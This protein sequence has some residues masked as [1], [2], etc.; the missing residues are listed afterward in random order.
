MPTEKEAEERAK[1]RRR[2][3]AIEAFLARAV[4]QKPNE[5][6][7]AVPKATTPGEQ[8]I[9]GARLL[10]EDA[11]A[12]EQLK[13][14]VPEA[15]KAFE[16]YA[17]AQDAVNALKQVGPKPLVSEALQKPAEKRSDER[18]EKCNGA[19]KIGREQTLSGGR[20]KALDDL[21]KLYRMAA[22]DPSG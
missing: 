9:R 10:I 5:V 19:V 11:L 7:E 21:R 13:A 20:L 4:E 17:D 6:S 18:W 12:D 3:E 15:V 2:A 22:G 8:L 14:W 1:Y 16:E